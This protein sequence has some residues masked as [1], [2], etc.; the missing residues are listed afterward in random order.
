MGSFTPDVVKDY[1]YEG[2]SEKFRLIEYYSKVKVP[3]YRILDKRKNQEKI[4]S[5][6]EEIMKI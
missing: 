2:S 5:K 6:E 3:Y 4:I 1:D